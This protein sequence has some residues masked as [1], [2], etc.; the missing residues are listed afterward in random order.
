MDDKVFYREIPS[1]GN[2][3]QER[4]T[5]KPNGFVRFL[6]VVFIQDIVLKAAALATS[7]LMWALI[8]GLV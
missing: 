6:K 1:N 7:A 8:V 3:L 4:K 5:N 2:D